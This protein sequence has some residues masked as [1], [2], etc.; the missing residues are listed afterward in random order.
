MVVGS[1]DLPTHTLKHYMCTI[2][3][4]KLAREER[5]IECKLYPCRMLRAGKYHT[6]I[7]GFY[8]G[9]KKLVKLNVSNI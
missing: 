9:Q 7:A 1:F 3:D 6:Y 5:F 8:N 4:R 2:N